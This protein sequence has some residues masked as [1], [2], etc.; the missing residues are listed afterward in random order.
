MPLFSCCWRLVEEVAHYL[1]P[2]WTVHHYAVDRM[3]SVYCSNEQ[4]L[5]AIQRA[6]LVHVYTAA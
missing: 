6:D 5:D 1:S 4:C 3:R 2:L